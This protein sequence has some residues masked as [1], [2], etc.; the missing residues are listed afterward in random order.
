MRLPK[1]FTKKEQNVKKDKKG[2]ILTI[3]KYIKLLKENNL[4]IDKVEITLNEVNEIDVKI[5]GKEG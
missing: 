3:D 1:I 4:K 2:Y 5:I